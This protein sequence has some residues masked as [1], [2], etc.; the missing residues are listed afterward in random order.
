M[1]IVPCST[2]TVASGSSNTR[3]KRPPLAPIPPSS[4]ATGMTPN[5]L[6]RAMNA[7]STPV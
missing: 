5:G 3:C 2:L 4:S 7:T 6:A 1:K